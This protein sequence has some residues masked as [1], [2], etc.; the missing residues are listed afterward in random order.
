MNQTV[1]KRKRQQR[2]I[3]RRVTSLF[4]FVELYESEPQSALSPAGVASVRAEIKIERLQGREIV[5]TDPIV[6]SPLNIA[7]GQKSRTRLESN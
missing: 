2:P 6:A 4:P 7:S 3:A 5:E 1:A